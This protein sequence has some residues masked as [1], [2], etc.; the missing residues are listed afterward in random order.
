MTDPQGY[1]PVSAGRSTGEGDETTPRSGETPADDNSLG[2]LLALSDGVFA[3][4]MT[5]L[6]LD[7]VVPTLGDHPND[8]ALRHA[9]SENIPSFL[10]FLISFYV[11]AGYWSRHRQLMRSVVA[12]HPRLY[13]DTLFLLLLVAAMPFPASLLGRYASDGVSLALYGTFNVLATLTVI[14]IRH[15]VSVLHLAGESSGQVL[16]PDQRSETVGNVV[17]FLLCIPA[18][19]LL[20]D[21]GSFV[22]LLLFVAGHGRS[23]WRRIRQALRRRTHQ[24]E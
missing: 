3:I 15:D 23:V 24:A 9:L 10:S 17:V 14:Q 1:S 19:Y 20:G 11:V 16:T 18:G 4:A 2:R 22:L 6:A 5:L 7:L 12:T 8:E 21:H 13:R